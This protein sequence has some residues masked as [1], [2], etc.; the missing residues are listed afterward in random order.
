MSKFLAVSPS[1]VSYN[2]LAANRK[3]GNNDLETYDLIM[4]IA[5][6]VLARDYPDIPKVPQAL[7]LGYTDYRVVMKVWMKEIQPTFLAFLGPRSTRALQWLSYTFPVTYSYVTSWLC[8]FAFNFLTGFAIRT[9]DGKGGGAY[10][11]H[12]HM[13]DVSRKEY[14]DELGT[15]ICT[16]ICKIFSEEA[17]AMKG[18]AIEFEPDFVTGSCMVRPKPPRMIAYHDHTLFN[19]MEVSPTQNNPEYKPT[20]SK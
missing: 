9:E 15:K 3:N 7:M 6:D 16:H 12:C 1:I 17:M 8:I 20:I 19:G 5:R 11:P 14:G 18:I 10:I 4:K 2:N 13:L